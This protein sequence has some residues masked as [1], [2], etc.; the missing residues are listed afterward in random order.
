MAGAEEEALPRASWPQAFP[1]AHP[2]RAWRVPCSSGSR[3]APHRA[4][5]SGALTAPSPGRARATRRGCRAGGGLRGPGRS[6]QGAGPRRPISSGAGRAPD[7][8]ASAQRRRLPSESPPSLP[9]HSSLAPPAAPTAPGR[10]PGPRPLTRPPGP[11]PRRSAPARAPQ[12]ARSPR[13]HG[14]GGLHQVHQVPALR[15]Q[16]RLLGEPRPAW[17][18]PGAPRGPQAAPRARPRRGGAAGLPSCGATCARPARGGG[19]VLGGQA[20]MVGVVR[21]AA[22]LDRGPGGCEPDLGAC[23]RWGPE[24]RGRAVAFGELWS[25]AAW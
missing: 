23:G 19:G 22:P 11:A 14:G 13:R 4:P 12:A 9:R 10:R 2:L 5:G 1:R 24:P 16:F 8:K 7:Q 18:G 20:A 21:G 6:R 25:V 3:R 15:L 17:G